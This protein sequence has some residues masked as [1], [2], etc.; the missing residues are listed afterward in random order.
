[1]R[2]PDL[3]LL[4]LTS[5]NQPIQEPCLDSRVSKAPRIHIGRQL[6]GFWFKRADSLTH[7]M[8]HLPYENAGDM[9]NLPTKYSTPQ[10]ESSLASKPQ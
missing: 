6:G 8:R 5:T 9:T 10:S 2:F 3:Q 7:T 4:N 1:M